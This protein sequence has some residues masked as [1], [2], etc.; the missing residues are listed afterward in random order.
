MTIQL[1]DESPMPWGKYKGT[2]MAEVPAP[3]LDW[4][5]GEMETRKTMNPV[6]RAVLDYIK[7]NLSAIRQ[8]LEET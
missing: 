6:S 3:Y 5:L 1:T 8:D 7:S 2:P 4:L